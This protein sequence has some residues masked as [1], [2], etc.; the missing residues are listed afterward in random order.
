MN[1]SPPMPASVTAQIAQLPDLPM[2]EIK[3]IWLKLFGG[4]TPNYNR[5]FLERRIAYRLQE[6]ECRKA[7]PH[8][9]DTNKQR[10]A[11]LMKAGKAKKRAAD[12][13][14]AAGTLLTREYRGKEYRVMATADGQYEFDGRLLPSL[15][16]I[17]REITGTRWSGPL[18]FGIKAPSKPKVK[19]GQ[20]GRK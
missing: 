19:A 1:A 7:D 13:R 4:G 6:L 3:T 20:G 5:P 2:P 15:S 8:L 9:L 11:A 12:C 16:M 10:I 14:P 18:F 17:A